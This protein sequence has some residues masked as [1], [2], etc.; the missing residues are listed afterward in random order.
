[1][2]CTFTDPKDKPDEGWG[3]KG[4]IELRSAPKSGL[5]TMYGGGGYVLYLGHTAAIAKSR[6]EEFRKKE[7][8]DKRTRGVHV[9]F[10]AY[11]P[12]VK[13]YFCS[14]III[15]FMETGGSYSHWYI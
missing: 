7:W 6:L 13:L 4:A 9:E 10:L 5:I 14:E 1:L 15:E 3:F 11:N 2:F 12:N 8:I